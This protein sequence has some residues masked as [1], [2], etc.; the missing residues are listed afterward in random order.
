[1]TTARLPAARIATLLIGLGVLNFVVTAF[2]AMVAAKSWGRMSAV[3]AQ[4]TL[5]AND[6]SQSARFDVATPESLAELRDGDHVETFELDAG[7]RAEVRVPRGDLERIAS[8]SN[9]LK[10]MQLVLPLAVS[11]L[12][13]AAGLRLRKAMRS[14]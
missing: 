8:T 12:F 11:F 1:M 14:I 6:G 7:T 13:L 5:F 4:V 9:T 10:V 2:V 3:H